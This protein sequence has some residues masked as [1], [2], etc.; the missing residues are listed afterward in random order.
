MLDS[1]VELVPNPELRA[2]I[3]WAIEYC[4]RP[5]RP[6]DWERRMRRASRL[7]HEQDV[8]S[9]EEWEGLVSSEAVAHEWDPVRADEMLQLDRLLDK[10]PAGRPRALRE[11]LSETM[12]RDFALLPQARQLAADGNTPRAIARLLEIDLGAVRRLLRG[13]D[14]PRQ[15]VD[16][17]RKFVQFYAGKTGQPPHPETLQAAARRFV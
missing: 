4:G 3:G 15:I 10:P 1:D 5:D 11:E 7:A 2:A 8:A 17:P 9:L 16:A 12:R 6:R 13:A 14:S